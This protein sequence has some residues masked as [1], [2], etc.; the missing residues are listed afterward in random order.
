MSDVAREITEHTTELAP[1]LVVMTAHGGAGPGGCS[2]GRSRSRSSAWARPLCFC[3]GPLPTPRPTVLREDWHAILAPIDGDPSHEKGLPVAAEMTASFGCKLH[4]LMVTPTPG[5]LGGS[6]PLPASSCPSRPAS[7][8]KWTMRGHGSIWPA[9]QRSSHAW[10]SSAG[11][12]ASRGDPARAIV[13]SRQT[14]RCRCRGHGN[15]W[16]GWRRCVLGRERCRA[17]GFPRAGSRFSS[18]PSGRRGVLAGEAHLHV[19]LAL[20][21]AVRRIQ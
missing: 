11:T 16:Q 8:W 19:G 18:C 10:G 13:R 6:R 2:R 14:R 3:S 1:D 17:R 21:D 12:E 4:L 7:S 5:D 9:G 15:A 20:G